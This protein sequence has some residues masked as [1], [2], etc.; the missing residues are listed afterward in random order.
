MI[1][2]VDVPAL[3]LQL[4]MRA[5]P[6]WDGEPMVVV[7]DDRPLAS[8]VWANR[9]ARTHKIRRG[10]SFAQAKALSARLHAEVVAES[11]LE[12]AID[13]LFELLMP[14]SPKVEPMLAQPSLFWLDPSELSLLFGD[15][16]R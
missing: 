11:A 4:V 9:A 3:A 8:I 14:I 15:L 7:E 12:S 1:A 2:C 10:Q 13:Q 6:E 16:S 5:H